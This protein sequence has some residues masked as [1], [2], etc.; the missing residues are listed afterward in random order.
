MANW[1]RRRLTKTALAFV[2]ASLLL[3][4]LKHTDAQEQSCGGGGGGG[5]GNSYDP[6]DGGGGGGGGSGCYLGWMNSSGQQC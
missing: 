3:L 4:D 6:D 1:T 5:G 2:S